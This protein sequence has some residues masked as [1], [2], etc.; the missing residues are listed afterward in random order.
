MC[1]GGSRSP[2]RTCQR[3]ESQCPVTPPSLCVSSRQGSVP[4]TVDLLARDSPGP[5]EAQGVKVS[6]PSPTTAGSGSCSEVGHRAAMEGALAPS[7]IPVRDMQ[8]LGRGSIQ[9]PGQ[10][11]WQGGRG[12]AGLRA[13]RGCS[14]VRSGARLV[15]ACML[16]DPCAPHESPSAPSCGTRRE[17]HPTCP[18]L[19]VPRTDQLCGERCR[20]A[21]HLQHPLHDLSLALAQ[22]GRVRMP[23]SFER[24]ADA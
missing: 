14:Y 5:S 23:M 22:G 12:R 15:L 19:T 13:A 24:Q 1:R 4:V 21:L 17:I 3:P 2:W 9:H 7:Q 18:A 8:L 10:L 6:L 16:R 11:A 20:Q